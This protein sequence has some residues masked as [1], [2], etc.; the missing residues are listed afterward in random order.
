MAIFFEV[1]FEKHRLLGNIF[2]RGTIL[3]CK[4]VYYKWIYLVEC[5]TDKKLLTIPEDEI[6]PLPKEVI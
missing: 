2:L 3:S 4:Y 6:W 5:A 1:S